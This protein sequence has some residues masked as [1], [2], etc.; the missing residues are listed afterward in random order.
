[1]TPV[2]TVDL[3]ALLLAL[4]A[5][6][7]PEQRLFLIALSGV[8]EAALLC[9]FF[10]APPERRDLNDEERLVRS[11]GLVKDLVPEDAE[12]SPAR[13]VSSLRLPNI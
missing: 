12:A 2:L 5:S 1:M 3:L 11:D 13:H 8:E 6:L 7:S 10:A 4:L 9:V